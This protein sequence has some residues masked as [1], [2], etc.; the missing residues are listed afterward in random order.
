LINRHNTDV[1]RPKGYNLD[2][3]RRRK[4]YRIM[5]YVKPFSYDIGIFMLNRLF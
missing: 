4:W 5:L 1:F 3:N 2:T